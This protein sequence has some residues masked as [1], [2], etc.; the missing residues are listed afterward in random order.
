MKAATG[1][2]GVGR[3]RDVEVGAGPAKWEGQ[4]VPRPPSHVIALGLASI[5][6]A[7]ACVSAAS[8][9]DE[10]ALLA[11]KGRDR[12]AIALLTEHLVRHPEAIEERRL[13]VRL[14]GS[15]GDLGAAEKQAAKLAEHLPESSPLP[16][17]DLGH[18]YELAH[19]Y[20]EA[21]ALYDQAS[22]IAP[23]DPRGPRTAGRRAARW[24]EAELAESRLEEAL[25]RDP[26]DA[27][28]WH[29]L[30]V[31][32]LH[33]GRLHA[34]ERAYRSGL[35]AD[36]DSVE[37]H[38]GLA[39][40]ALRRDDPRAALVHYEAV[41]ARRPRLA[42]VHL[43]RA[44]SLIRLGR[45]QEAAAALGRADRLGADRDV[46][47]AQRRLLNALSNRSIRQ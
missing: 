39:T 16:F 25:R 19:R 28:T 17:I 2:L 23:G 7:A 12:E 14:H 35:V 9:V 37:N 11:D 43:G 10:A 20:E 32:R 44:W 46:I 31:V 4:R 38:L 5:S 34:A 8:P 1:R 29:A 42:D 41:L 22:A 6:C 30:G 18:A 47:A 40:V 15:V 26:S 27:A 21:L 24:G 13:L 3:G 33:L 45:L 36:P